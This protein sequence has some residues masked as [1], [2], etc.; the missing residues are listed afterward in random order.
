MRSKRAAILEQLQA[1]SL[2]DDASFDIG[3]AALL[4]AA[5]DHPGTALTPYRAHLSALADDARHATTR[6]ASVGV[7]VMALQ[8]V[9]LTRHGYSAGEADPASWGDV[10]LID[11]IDQRQGQAAALGILYVHAARAYG[12]A[13]EVL[14]FPQSF[15]VR[16]TA[17]GQRVIIDPADVRRTLDA[18]DLR[19][20]LKLLQGQAAEVNAAHYEAISDREALFRLYNGLKISA[21]AAGTLPRALDILEAL[22]VLVPARSELWWETGVLLSRLGNVSTAIS[23]LEAYL[24]AAAPASGRDQIE[25]LLK[26]LRAR[27]P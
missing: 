13:I 16:L 3:E 9:L 26:R 1:V 14:N 20:R 27:A 4:L 8:R 18:G 17:R 7:Q 11:A 19:R 24:S 12:A 10:D 21:I 2:T 15:L 22:R 23:T 6:L 25:D 5:F